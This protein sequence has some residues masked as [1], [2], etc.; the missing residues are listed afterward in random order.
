MRLLKL[1]GKIK[2]LQV[3]V[4]GLI[5][6]LSAVSY[7]ILLMLLIFY[8]FAV[9]GVSSFRENDPFHFGSLGMAMLSLFRAATLEDWGDI[10]FINWFGCDSGFDAVLGVYT[11][12]ES[13]EIK[14]EAG[15]FM[16]L[17]CD[18]PKGQPLL[19]AFFFIAFI[20]IAAFVTMALFV[21][22]VCGGMYE[23]I[24]DFR[25][26]QEEEKKKKRDEIDE[27]GDDSFGIGF[28][29]KAFRT[30]FDAVDVDFSG[31]IDVDELAE[32]IKILGIE[33][34]EL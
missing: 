4:M 25:A 32:A 17:G 6:G 14:T 22:A 5:K 12:E 8:L 2:Q 31:M 30:A 24:D 11:S 13:Y 26:Q 15:V 34:C 18:K 21:G 20:L 19:S 3:I 9:M 10:M 23:A 7:I 33:V 27:S 29:R 1:V 28:N 16:G